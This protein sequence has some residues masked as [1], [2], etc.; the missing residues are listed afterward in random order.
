[1]TKL[2]IMIGQGLSTVAY[3]FLFVFMMS[4]MLVRGGWW[5]LAGI[6]TI[7]LNFVVMRYYFGESNVFEVDGGFPT[8]VTADNDHSPD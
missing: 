2:V 3:I 8:D 5:I 4:Q 7:L 6:A 1:M